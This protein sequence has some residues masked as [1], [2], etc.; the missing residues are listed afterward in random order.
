MGVLLCRGWIE[1]LWRFL[2]E[3]PELELL[4]LSRA[5]FEESKYTLIS[6]FGDLVGLPRDLPSDGIGD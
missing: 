2:A 3:E 5:Q 4:L 1:L 6:D